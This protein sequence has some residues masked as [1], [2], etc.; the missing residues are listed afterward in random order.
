MKSIILI[1]SMLILSNLYAVE[2]RS[3]TRTLTIKVSED[4]IVTA[5]LCNMNGTGCL[6]DTMSVEIGKERIA[7]TMAELE[8]LLADEQRIAEI[9]ATMR[10][11]IAEQGSTIMAFGLASLN[12]DS[13]GIVDQLLDVQLPQVKASME[14]IDVEA[15]I[16][17]IF[18]QYRIYNDKVQFTKSEEQFGTFLDQAT[19]MLMLQFK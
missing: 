18:G 4:S 10:Q 12:A 16:P 5:S 19:R 8:K 13:M 7:A 11:Q 1:L 15:L 17:Q 3:K 2:Y 9:K 14:Q 6:S